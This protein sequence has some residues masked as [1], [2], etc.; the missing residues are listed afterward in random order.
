M[1]IIIQTAYLT[2]FSTTNWDTNPYNY[3]GRAS[4]ARNIAAK[5]QN[6]VLYAADPVGAQF[7]I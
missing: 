6:T 7:S 5:G 4:L 2:L 1:D 3:L